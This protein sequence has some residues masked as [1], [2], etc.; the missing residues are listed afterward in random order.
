MGMLQGVWESLGRPRSVWWER[1]RLWQ[2]V[3]TLGRLL[4][5]YASVELFSSLAK[6]STALEAVRVRVFRFGTCR[7]QLWTQ[8]VLIGFPSELDRSSLRQQAVRTR[9]R[10]REH[11]IPQGAI[12]GQVGSG[13]SPPIAALSL[14]LDHPPRRRLATKEKASFPLRP[15]SPTIPPHGDDDHHPGKVALHASWSTTFSEAGWPNSDALHP[16]DVVPRSSASAL[17]RAAYAPEVTL[18]PH[19]E[20]ILGTACPQTERSWASISACQLYQVN[21]TCPE[22]DLPNAR[23]VLLSQQRSPILVIVLPCA[24]IVPS[25]DDRDA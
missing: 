10:E 5:S 9:G 17:G 11:G 23:T 19:W 25:A 8:H 13:G 21:Q 15:L 20:Q 14:S 7:F 4:S 2:A 12:S 18:L 24:F 3:D 22:S 16:P 1:V 6:P